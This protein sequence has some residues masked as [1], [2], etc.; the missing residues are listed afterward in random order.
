MWRNEECNV[1][2]GR[3]R[4]EA[5]HVVEENVRRCTPLFR[6]QIPLSSCG[7]NIAVGSLS[8][9][10]KG[11]WCWRRVEA[12][13]N[14]VQV[15]AM[16]LDVNRRRSKSRCQHRIAEQGRDGSS[17]GVEVPILRE[18]DPNLEQDGIVVSVPPG[19]RARPWIRKY[20]VRQGRRRC[21]LECLSASRQQ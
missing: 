2:D 6:Q 15:A 14:K 18:G 13:S 8:P 11:C 10:K 3:F 16:P 5:I 20:L 12:D 9:S 1:E 4:Y 17:G 21:L 7:V 19:L